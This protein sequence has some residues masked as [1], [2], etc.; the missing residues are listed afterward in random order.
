[1]N[2]A[3]LRDVQDLPKPEKRRYFQA[4]YPHRINID[5][6][7][8]LIIRTIAGNNTRQEFAQQQDELSVFNYQTWWLRS[9]VQSAVQEALW[10]HVWEDTVSQVIEI[11]ILRTAI[12]RS[13]WQ[14]KHNFRMKPLDEK[15]KGE[16]IEEHEESCENNGVDHDNIAS[17]LFGAL[18]D[19][20]VA[21]E[22]EEAAVAA[23]KDSKSEEE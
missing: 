13:V 10:A 1:M 22:K 12:W 11:A 23:A 5:Y 8:D 4:M 21:I 15:R 20:N 3:H 14:I 7:D 6:I 9:R 16:I 19:I 2:E 18:H 17:P